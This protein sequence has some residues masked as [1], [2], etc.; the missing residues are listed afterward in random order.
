M[1]SNRWIFLAVI[2]LFRPH[3]EYDSDGEEVKIRNG[4][5]DLHTP[6]QEQGRCQLPFRY[7]KRIKDFIEL[8]ALYPCFRAVIKNLFP[9]GAAEE[10]I[11]KQTY[12]RSV[13]VEKF[14]KNS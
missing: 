2:C 8:F 12:F 5:P 7:F 13:P 14:I 6:E 1:G 4:N 9:V 11:I 3:I 10:I